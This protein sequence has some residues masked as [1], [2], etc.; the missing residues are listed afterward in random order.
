MKTI[1][2]ISLL[3]IAILGIGC[4]EL[5]KETKD[6][7]EFIKGDE[8]VKVNG[9]TLK[10][11]TTDSLAVAYEAETFFLSLNSADIN[12]QANKTKQAFL[13]V[14][15]WEFAP[16]DAKLSLDG[17]SI[18]LS[19]KSNNPTYIS[20]VEGNLPE[21]IALSLA[22][23]SGNVSIL[24]FTGNKEIDV[25]SIS[26]ELSLQNISAASLILETV[27]GDITADKLKIADAIAASSTS[28]EINITASEAKKLSAKT[29][30]GDIMV[31]SGSFD[32]TEANSTSGN[33]NIQS[34]KIASKQLSSV[35]GK[36][37]E[38][39]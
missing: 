5:S 36:I 22:S 2:I 8:A 27:S 16:G 3:I 37:T 26:G 39:K 14:T 12:L 1:A 20:K 4:H 10:H 23:V 17:V 9:V 21:A 32:S 30:S 33:I 25:K 34:S 29:V 13:R 15:Y 11:Q 7:I 19:S 28:G 38:S 6:I 18:K 24:G 31:S 35:S